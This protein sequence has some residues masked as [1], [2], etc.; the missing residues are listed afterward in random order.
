M[1]LSVC[2]SS[3]FKMGS[4][5]KNDHKTIQKSWTPRRLQVSRLRNKWERA[6]CKSILKLTSCCWLEHSSPLAP[7]YGLSIP[8]GLKHN[9][10]HHGRGL[11]A[12]PV[13]TL[14]KS[15]ELPQ[16]IWSLSIMRESSS[17][18]QQP[19]WTRYKARC[20]QWFYSN[21]ST[22]GCMFLHI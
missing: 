18:L 12:L 21:Y 6:S 14:S 9:Q 16:T 15:P 5:L 8:R 1:L 19:S 22:G 20:S 4:I 10:C 3:C 13:Y 17:F 2:V 7:A 11:R